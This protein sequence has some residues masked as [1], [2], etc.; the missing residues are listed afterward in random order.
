MGISVERFEAG[1]PLGHVAYLDTS[2]IISALDV[3]LSR[4]E[5]PK[6]IL[7]E[8]LK[9]QIALLVSPLAIDEVWWTLV[10]E[11][12]RLDGHLNIRD[13]LKKKPET[14]LGPYVPRLRL[15]TDK[16][17][18]WPNLKWVGFGETSGGDS[19]RASVSRAL[20]YIADFRLM[21]RDAFHLSH[22]V[23]YFAD[24]F[25]TSDPDFDTLDGDKRLDLRIIKSL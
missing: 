3:A 18:R 20:D 19:V 24:T 4:P 7:F 11:W 21:P 5:A 13:N 10:H 16:I 23:A 15:I 25:I 6:Y 14:Y 17:S 22:A 12:N 8:L 2:F 1:M 9:A